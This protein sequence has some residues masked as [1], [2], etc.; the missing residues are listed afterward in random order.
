MLTLK[1]FGRKLAVNRAQRDLIYS[2]VFYK[3]KKNS[4]EQDGLVL[5]KISWHGTQK[6]E[7]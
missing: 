5:R 3:K 7:I 1:S 4:P 6:S 2:P